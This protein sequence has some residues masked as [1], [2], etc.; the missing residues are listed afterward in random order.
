VPFGSA[1]YGLDASL[2]A[3]SSLSRRFPVAVPFAFGALVIWRA[4]PPDALDSVRLPRPPARKGARSRATVPPD[5]REALERGEDETVTLAEWLAIDAT[6][7]LR[8]L[9]PAVGFD[10]GAAEGIVAEAE[11]RAELAFVARFDAIA[12][13]I[14]VAIRRTR[15]GAKV[16]ERL[17]TH[18]SDMARSWAALAPRFDES[19]SL[20][21][22]LAVAMRFAADGAM[23]VRE[24]AWTAIRPAVSAELDAAIAALGPWVRHPNDGVRRCAIEATR[25]R[26]VWC[27][28][29]DRLRREPELGRPLLEPVRADE[30]RY[31]LTS[32]ANWINDASKT[33]SDW[34]V[35]ICDRWRRESPTSSTSW[36][37]DHALRT[38]RKGEPTKATKATKAT[39]AKKATTKLG[40][41]SSRPSRGT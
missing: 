28:H 33:R 30:S 11:N 40:K 24:T 6:R 3:V 12:R 27:A 22:R 31:V 2:V 13:D 36:L 8:N 23:A 39:T 37:V 17:A 25:P 26:G 10:P 38:L 1:C 29:I 41:E 14:S 5:V 32:A 21:E 4:V 35:D 16:F 19:L 34:V 7:L 15:G 20:D 9:L 18:R